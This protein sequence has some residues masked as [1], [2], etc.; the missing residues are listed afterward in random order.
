MA[1]DMGPSLELGL[2]RGDPSAVTPALCPSRCV[3]RAVS[4]ALWSSRC[5]LQDGAGGP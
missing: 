4:R 3:P 2:G 1:S 5:V